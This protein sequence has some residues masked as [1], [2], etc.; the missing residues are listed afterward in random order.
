VI[1]APFD[2]D[3]TYENV[4]LIFVDSAGHSSVVAANPRDRAARAFDLLHERV[5]GRLDAVARQRRCERAYLWRWA[6]DGGFLVVHD[7]DESIARDVAIEYAKSLLE[8]DLRHLRDE[9]RQLAIGGQ[10]HLRIAVHRGTIQYRGSGLEGSVYSPDINFA[11]HLER[12]APVDT[13]A[14][15]EDVYRVA[16]PFTELF[17]LAGSY[18]GRQVYLFTG[19]PEPGAGTRA[20]LAAHGLAGAGPVFGY[21]ERPNQVEKAR[22]VKAAT[23]EVIDLG[24]ALRTGA[25]YLVTTERPAY[26]RDA[27]LDF[28]RR[29]GR[30]RCIMMDPNGEAARQLSLQRRED[31][32]SKIHESLASFRRFKD[33]AGADADGLEVYQTRSCPTMGCI[34]IDLDEPHAMILISPYLTAP[35]P[36]GYQIELSELPHYLVGPQAGHLFDNLRTLIRTFAE[37]DVTRVL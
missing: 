29:G 2:A 13:V 11:A 26:M 8:L 5:V 24:S 36:S 34:S 28:L 22:L 23:A 3:R 1:N 18:E 30:Y 4:F 37:Q 16:G 20:W 7:T 15:S 35:E 31:I 6:G 14:I 17:E 12:A 27:T 33:R 19:S 9:F 10:L 25:R 21:A 32:S